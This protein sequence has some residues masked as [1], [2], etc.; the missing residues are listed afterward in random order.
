M[1]GFCRNCGT[2]LTG[3]FCGKCGYPADAAPP[4]AQ[5][6]HAPAQRPAA[7][8]A[9][10]REAQMPVATPTA[11]GG[12]LGKALLIVALIFGVFLV[13]GIGGAFYALHWAKKKVATYSA[14]V[15]GEHPEQVVVAHGNSCALLSK[16]ELQEV[17]GVTIEKTEEIEE[18]DNP[19]CAYFASADGF[20][21]LRKMAVE[22]AKRESARA[23]AAQKP[24]EKIDNPL[25][26]LKD[27]KDMEGMIKTFGMQQPAKDG[28]VFS[29]TV[30]RKTGAD[31][32]TAMRTSMALIPGFAEV[33]GV[34]DHAM[35]GTFGHV[36]YAFQ[37]NTSI[38]L[39]TMVVP[40]AQT[41][42]A[43]LARKI[44]ARL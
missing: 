23:Q 38:Q 32:W 11:K 42:G 25:E 27:T 24:G 17:L 39:N 18:S 20:A 6:E 2:P 34:G 37:G 40:D 29:F 1:A 31:S 8:A 14:E 21:Q 30:N 15:S 3:Q 28:Q 33:P 7:E 41:N 19:G 12:G 44:L 36:F 13:L 10:S 26:L 43:T 5:T 4:T 9:A 16:S 35:V 22:E